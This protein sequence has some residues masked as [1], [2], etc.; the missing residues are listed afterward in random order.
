[1][2]NEEMGK[3]EEVTLHFTQQ[4]ADVLL[5][6]SSNVMRKSMSIHAL[7][8]LPDSRHKRGMQWHCITVCKLIASISSSLLAAC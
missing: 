1:M 6:Q 8:S 5:P 3:W 2:G 4:T 7:T